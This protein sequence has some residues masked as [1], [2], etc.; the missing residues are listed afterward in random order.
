MRASLSNSLVAQELCGERGGPDKY[1][2]RVRRWTAHQICMSSGTK[3]FNTNK[4]H[5]NIT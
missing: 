1:G 2:V 4:M 3:G 5:K